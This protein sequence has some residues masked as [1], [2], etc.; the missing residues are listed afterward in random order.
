MFSDALVEFLQQAVAS[1]WFFVALFTFSALDAFVPMVPSETLVIAAGVFAAT[2][3]AP[4]IPIVLAAAAGAIAGDH[5]SYL[6]GRTAGSRVLALLSRSPR[7]RKVVGWAQRALQERGPAIL[8]V[9]RYVPG[10]RTAVTMSAGALRYPVKVFTPF[11]VLAG[12]TWATYSALVGYLG[13]HL[14]ED[15][16]GLALIA[17]LGFGLAVA[18]MVELAG[19]VLRRRAATAEQEEPAEDP[20]GS[21]R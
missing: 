17:G 6:I 10:G 7:G 5:I 9:A 15:N 14:F 20:V 16:P 3:D 11:I 12:L 18:G 1:P 21:S 19:T 13:G 2:G 8:V 4:L